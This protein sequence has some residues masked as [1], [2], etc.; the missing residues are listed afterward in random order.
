MAAGGSDFDESGYRDWLTESGVDYSNL[1]VSET[2]HDQDG[3]FSRAD[4]HVHGFK[5]WGRAYWENAQ[6]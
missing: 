1:Y 3:R 5:S 6:L 4:R 2:L